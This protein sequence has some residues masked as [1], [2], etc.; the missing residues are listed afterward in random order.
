[1]KNFNEHEINDFIDLGREKNAPVRFI[2]MMD[3]IDPKLEF[4][5]LAGIKDRLIKEGIIETNGFQQNNSVAVY[6]RL[7]SSEG[8]IG[9]ITPISHSF[10]DTCTKIRLMAN[11]EIKLCLFDHRSYPLKPILRSGVP[12]D[13]LKDFLTRTVKD[14]TPHP[15]DTRGRET[16]AKMGG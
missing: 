15:P 2:E 3:S 4:V 1:M 5:S 6:H 7:R 14:K 11:G 13:E 16:I 8:V 10:C 12:D 9:F